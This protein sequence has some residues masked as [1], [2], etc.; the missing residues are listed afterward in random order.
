M[1]MPRKSIE[2][3][4]NITVST[5]LNMETAAKLK[6]VAAKER[7]SKAFIIREA[8]EAHIATLEVK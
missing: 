7:R 5:D 6:A 1:A 3:G 2:E 4:L 8:I